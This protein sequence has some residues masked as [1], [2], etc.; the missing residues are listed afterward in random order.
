MLILKMPGHG[1][2][3][4]ADADSITVLHNLMILRLLYVELAV[5]STQIEQCINRTSQGP[6][7]R[8]VLPVLYAQHWLPII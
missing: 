8:R 5:K 7:P 1:A 2:F 6:T 4:F 3:F